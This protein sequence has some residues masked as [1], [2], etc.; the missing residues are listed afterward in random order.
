[1]SWRVVAMQF[2]ELFNYLKKNTLIKWADGDFEGNLG[3]F[4]RQD[5]FDTEI[6]VPWVNLEKVS[7]E[8]LQLQLTGGKDVEQ[9]TRVTGFF[10]KV[11]SWNK[12]KLAELKDRH[13]CQE[14]FA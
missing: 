3:I 1:M 8:D 4:L 5:K 6:H 10:S 9:I 14:Y 12:G 7:L 13:R 11:S 2:E